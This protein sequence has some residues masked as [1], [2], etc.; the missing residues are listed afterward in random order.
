MRAR[1]LA[2]VAATTVAACAG[3]QTLD[4]SARDHEATARALESQDR[5]DDALREREQA[6][7]AHE[8]HARFERHD[9]DDVPHPLGVGR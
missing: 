4:R 2:V 9:G 6:D 3:S 8:D 7:D 5:Y 1:I